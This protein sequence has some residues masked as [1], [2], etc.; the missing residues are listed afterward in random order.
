MRAAEGDTLPASSS[1]RDIG[2]DDW[3]FRR[4]H[5]YGTLIVDL[6]RR[7]PIELLSDRE[8]ATV[9]TWLTQHP[10][11]RVVARDRARTYAEAIR[12]G[13]PQAMQVADRWHLLKNLGETL[14]RLLGRYRQTLRDTAHELAGQT[15]PVTSSPTPGLRPGKQQQLSQ[16]RRACCLARYEE[17]VRLRQGGMAIS[18]ISRVSQLDRRTV[19]R[20][21]RAGRIPERASRQPESGKLDPYCAYLAQRGHPAS[22]ADPMAQDGAN[23]QGTR[24]RGTAIAALRQCLVAGNSYRSAQGTE[25]RERFVDCLCHANPVI[26]AVRQL[27]NDFIAMLG[28]RQ[29]PNLAGWLRRV[30]ASGIRE[31]CRFADGLAR[32]YDA[33]RAAL[34]THCSSGMVESRINRLKMLKRQM[35]GR[36]G[37]AL[38]RVRVLR[39]DD[40]SI[41]VA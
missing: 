7:C 8:T 27:S 31:L 37:I 38:S 10:Q 20:W 32:D 3:A 24:Q 4:D 36:A 25:Y 11:V 1:V 6:Q 9:A 28:K 14:E 39:R 29:A 12:Q 22:P 17:V 35:Y 41:P 5:R 30:H 16:Q 23:D 2:I 40:S 19:C 34:T 26:D 18:A 13:A 33:V 21:L 15:V